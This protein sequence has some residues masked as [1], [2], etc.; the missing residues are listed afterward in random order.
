[1]DTFL[2]CKESAFFKVPDGTLV[3]PFLNPKDSESSL[4]WDLLDGVSVAAGQINPGIASEIHVHPYVSQITLLL[5]GS[6]RIVLRQPGQEREESRTLHN[7][8]TEGK[9]GFPLKACVARPGAFIQ[10]DNTD[11]T[12]PA[13]VLYLVSPCYVFESGATTDS[14]PVYD[15]AITL[16]RDWARLRQLNWNPP[17]LHS[18]ERSYGQRRL[19]IERL[20]ATRRTR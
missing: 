2:E 14:S 5:S 13:R 4:P 6:L 9:G 20:A 8:E 17:E 11:G 10:L 1:M 18:V 7:R 15:D 19:A 12:Q 16:G 3:N